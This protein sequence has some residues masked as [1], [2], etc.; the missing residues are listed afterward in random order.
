MRTLANPI[1]LQLLERLSSRPAGV[2]VSELARGLRLD[3]KTVSK[4]L[5]SLAHDGLVVHNRD[6]GSVRYLLANRDYARIG[7]LAYRAA[8]TELDVIEETV[9]PT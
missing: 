2:T 1:R 6:G 4:H 8:V 5:R 9:D 3:G 7:A